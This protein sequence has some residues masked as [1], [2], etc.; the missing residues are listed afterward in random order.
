M[1]LSSSV[2]RLGKK[3]NEDLGE[4][5]N[6]QVNNNKREKTEMGRA[7]NRDGSRKAIK[8]VWETRNVGRNRK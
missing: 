1:K 7:F 4:A 5:N 3:V 6:V 8:Q 2:K